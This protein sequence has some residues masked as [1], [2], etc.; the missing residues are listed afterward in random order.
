MVRHGVKAMARNQM[1]NYDSYGNLCEAINRRNAAR[2]REQE[3]R[4][5][6]AVKLDMREAWKLE[7]SESC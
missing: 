3:R 2:L 5:A 7:E 6:R 4:E 1:I